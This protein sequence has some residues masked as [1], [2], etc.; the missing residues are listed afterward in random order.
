MASWWQ[1]T[2][3]IRDSLQSGVQSI[4]QATKDIAQE[5]AEVEE[6][7]FEDADAELEYR[8]NGASRFEAMYMDLEK[9]YNAQRKELEEIRSVNAINQQSART[10]TADL[11]AA[12]ET[13]GR[14]RQQHQSATHRVAEL[15]QRI[16]R[17]SSGRVPGDGDTDSVSAEL[18]EQIETT[19]TENVHLKER[20]SAAQ[21][22][23]HEFKRKTK[24]KWDEVKSRF[25]GQRQNTKALE[26]QVAEWRQKYQ[27][28]AA[29]K[30][31]S[32]DAA[33]GDD[34]T[35]KALRAELEDERRH[36]VEEEASF[37]ESLSALKAQSQS[38][39]D[40][41]TRKM[42]DIESKL[43]RSDAKCR[44]LE[45]VNERDAQSMAV[46]SSQ[47]QQYKV[48]VEE[49]KREME[50]LREEMAQSK[51]NALKQLS[52]DDQTKRIVDDLKADNARWSDKNGVLRETVH[53]LQSQISSM[54]SECERFKGTVTRRLRA[55]K[56]LHAQSVAEK[57]GLKN[58]YQEVACKYRQ[59]EAEYMDHRG[60]VDGIESRHE[61]EVADLKEAV[62]TLRAE[63]VRNESLRSE[64]ISGHEA[65]QSS[66]VVLK[67]EVANL[68]A[69]M[70]ESMGDFQTLVQQKE[71]ESMQQID[72]FLRSLYAVLFKHGVVTRSD[73]ESEGQSTALPP[74]EVQLRALSEWMETATA[75]R[76]ESEDAAEEEQ[77]G[78]I[79]KQ[80]GVSRV[81]AAKL[82][83]EHHGDADA[84]VLELTSSSNAAM[85][86]QASLHRERAVHRERVA[87]LESARKRMA[88]E[89][90]E[91]QSAAKAM[92]LESEALAAEL[93]GEREKYEAL[94]T[95]YISACNEV[96]EVTNAKNEVE[97]ECD[98]LLEAA[99]HHQSVLEEER[100]STQ[101]L[102]EAEQERADRAVAD[103]KRLEDA[104]KVLEAQKADL[105]KQLHSKMKSELISDQD[106][107]SNL[108]SL[109]S[110]MEAVRG[111][112]ERLKLTLNSVKELHTKSVA[113]KDGDIIE[114]NTVINALKMECE[115]L[116]ALQSDYLELTASNR[117]LKDQFAAK[118]EA[119]DNLQIAFDA[120]QTQSRKMKATMPR[121]SASGG[122]ASG[123]IS[124]GGDGGANG[125]RDEGGVEQRLR[126]EVAA[127]TLK[128]QNQTKQLQE[129][130]GKFTQSQKYQ[131]RLEHETAQLR[132]LC[133]KTAHKLKSMAHSDDNIDRK[134]IIKLLVTFFDRWYN[135]GDTKEVI[136][137][138]AK[139]LNFDEKEKQKCRV[140]SASHSAVGGLWGFATSWITA[141]DP[142][143]SKQGDGAMDSEE[144]AQDLGSLW[145]EF[146]LNELGDNE[147]ETDGA[148]TT[149]RNED[150]LTEQ[151]VESRQMSMPLSAE[152][153]ELETNT[154]TTTSDTNASSG[155]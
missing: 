115:E 121:H 25:Q 78:V 12:Q 132:S 63:C 140:Y 81:L 119:F 38:A 28:L 86:E 74:I 69:Q 34:E 79:V 21:E 127:M 43:A 142:D 148:G 105:T 145:V 52:M 42:E 4:K 83:S 111:E 109:R 146:L 48:L 73:T 110:E 2:E 71:A 6:E 154:V 101:E 98:R 99:E 20:L 9:A 60:K 36:R 35:V 97:D 87:E 17:L 114:L 153:A 123:S 113:E 88:L 50:A 84:V 116:R 70:R 54:E 80:C 112:N 136:E 149:E 39:L 118:R 94:E 3:A 32:Q 137:L 117:A 61:Q 151:S 106:R 104:H 57:E 68:E 65:M 14:L 89:V 26:Q 30:A 138:I 144:R 64:A 75:Q 134:I 1:N 22:E 11:D 7:E 130:R 122:S 66:N 27:D 77:I 45:A 135:G 96:D 8:A 37:R 152:S 56:Q 143:E 93:K 58:G 155:S 24:S 47:H 131:I 95:R 91:A 124:V 141:A 15:E 55:I 120:L 108:L 41:V 13:N 128:Y 67:Q 46:L 129:V 125:G 76:V 103:L 133:S 33:A 62:E 72:D 147:I 126:E 49:Q 139:I 107:S 44:E 31:S 18:R 10:L 53:R 100:M 92:R 16:S 5:L 90:E 59:M 23:L 85:K 40:E 29:S 19:S 82:L 51:D 102:I 150:A